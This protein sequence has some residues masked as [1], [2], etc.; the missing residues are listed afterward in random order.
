ML[1]PWRVVP[2]K[3]PNPHEDL[4]IDEHHEEA[5]KAAEARDWTPMT[6]DLVLEA[7]KTMIFGRYENWIGDQ[8]NS[9]RS[10]KNY[11]EK[12]EIIYI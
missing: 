1:I 3:K 10:V 2:K 12:Y 7:L 6:G 8:Q 9:T 5:T 4:S 11:L